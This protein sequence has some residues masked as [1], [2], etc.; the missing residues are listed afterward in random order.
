M[1]LGAGETIGIVAAVLGLICAPFVY[2]WKKMVGRV[3]Q[4]ET[5]VD[6]MHIVQAEQGKDIKQL[7][8]KTDEMHD[9]LKSH[10]RDEERDRRESSKLLT[11]IAAKLDIE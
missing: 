8:D 1:A 9:D 4:L 11:K 2:I 6:A 3:E 7:V 5:E 10:I